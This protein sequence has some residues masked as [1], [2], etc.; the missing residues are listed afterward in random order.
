MK[1]YTKPPIQRYKKTYIQVGL[2][3]IILQLEKCLIANDNDKV[4]TIKDFLNDRIGLFETL[5]LIDDI[6]YKNC[7]FDKLDLEIYLS[8]EATKTHKLIR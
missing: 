8:Y 7:L 5:D 1:F 4:E 3:D 2:N 6:K